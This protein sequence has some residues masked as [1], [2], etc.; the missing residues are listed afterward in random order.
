MALKLAKAKVPVHVNEGIAVQD[1]ATLPREAPVNESMI[2]DASVLL[3]D[4]QLEVG[5]CSHQ[6]DVIFVRIGCLPER[7]V[8]R[9]DAQTR[10]LA[11]GDT[12]G[13]RHVCER[14]DVYDCDPEQV[15]RLIHQ[16]NGCEVKQTYCGV[17]FVAPAEPTA[18]DVTHPEHGNQGFPAGAVI[19]VVHQRSLDQDQ[20]EIRALD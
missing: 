20:R 14:G 18:D 12:R 6:G 1:A 16:A 9:S 11:P 5:D 8:R 4:A 7:A 3:T 15:A 2:N 10:Q 19:A 17:C 13:S